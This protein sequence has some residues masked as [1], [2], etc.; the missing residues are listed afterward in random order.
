MRLRCSRFPR[1]LNDIATHS[2]LGGQHGEEA[3]DEDEVGG[4]KGREEDQA[5]EEEVS[6]RRFSV[7]DFERRR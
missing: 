7:F 5:P 3:K 2:R 6:E 1:A 4:E